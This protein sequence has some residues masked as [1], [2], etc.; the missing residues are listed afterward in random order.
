MAI[1]AGPLFTF[2]LSISF[3]VN[4]DPSKDTNARAELEA[5]WRELSGGG[6]A[7]MPMDSYPFSDLYGWI[8][9]R[10]RLSWQVTPVIMDEMMAHGTAEQVARVTKAFLPMK[11][12][13]IAAP[14]KAYESR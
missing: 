9:D 7:L 2:N 12:F 14:R 3:I 8:Q 11:K 10:Y 4:F 1:S 5:M 13:D 6:K